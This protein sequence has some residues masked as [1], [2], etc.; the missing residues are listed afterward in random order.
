LFKILS[1]FE[2]KEFTPASSNLGSVGKYIKE[3]PS[4][5]SLS[6]LSNVKTLDSGIPGLTSTPHQPI[7][8]TLL[9]DA[10]SLEL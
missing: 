8:S 6:A 10:N 4:I 9:S 3:L 2:I 5:E 7:P 1:T